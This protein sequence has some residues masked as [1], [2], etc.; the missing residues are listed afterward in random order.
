MVY[1]I[2][3][4]YVPIYGRIFHSICELVQKDQ[5]ANPLTLEHYFA[6]D[7][8]F[9]DIGGKEFLNKLC[10]GILG[11]PLQRIILIF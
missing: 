9:I 6:Q 8:A 5:I 4:F 2:F 1:Q 7:D 11:N 10:E 3:T